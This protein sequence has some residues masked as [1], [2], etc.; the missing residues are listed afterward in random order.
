MPFHFPLQAVLHLRQ[1]L[2][3]QQELRLRVANQQVAQMQ[4]GVAQVEARQAELHEDQSRQ[5][6][7]GLT[8]AELRFALQCEAQLVRH[9][10]ELEQQLL[11]RLQWRDQQRELFQ[12]ARRAREM[13]ES[14]RDQKLRTYNLEA[15]R[16]LQR[17]LADLF[18][19][20]RE[21]LRRG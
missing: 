7:E 11:R 9:K 10:R 21:Y 18:L 20:R 3:H 1:S 13:L 14:V 15:V 8:A 16:R 17:D 4:Q 6:A 12:Q 19:M 5:L 2:E